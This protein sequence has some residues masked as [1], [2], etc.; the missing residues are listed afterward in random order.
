MRTQFMTSTM[1]LKLGLYH[2]LHQDLNQSN[3]LH[4][5]SSSRN[6]ISKN[7][8]S[9][10][11]NL[12]GGTSHKTKACFQN[13]I[14]TRCIYGDWSTSSAVVRGHPEY[15]CNFWR[16]TSSRVAQRKRAGPITQRS[17]DR[18]LPLLYKFDQSASRMFLLSQS[19]WVL[20]SDES[21]LHLFLE[22][23]KLSS[24]NHANFWLDG[25]KT[26]LTL[27]G[28]VYIAEE[29]FDPP[30]SG[31]WAQHASAAPLCCSSDIKY[32]L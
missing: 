5:I 29:G 23:Q 19:N 27:I 17:E 14:I 1:K 32:F 31:L 12:R 26:F 16:P 8:K 11:R 30:T 6:E 20:V 18:N 25:E 2:D 22:W 15:I 28:Q 7:S 3:S 13:W 21:F 10:F 4:E 9:D 24:E